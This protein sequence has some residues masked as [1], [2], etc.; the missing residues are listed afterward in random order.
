MKSTKT[1]LSAKSAILLLLVTVCSVAVVA[2]PRL[3][4]YVKEGLQNNIVAQQ[5]AIAYEQAQRSLQIATGFFLP[6]VSLLADYT[7][8]EG[9]RSIAIPVGDMLNPVYA[10]LNQLTQS[11]AFRQIDN[12]QQNFFP[13]NFYDGRIRTSMPLINTD[14]YANRAIQREQVAIRN[15]ELMAYKRQLVM[16]IKTAYYQYL[17]ATAAVKILESGLG[18]VERNVEVNA[19]LLRNGKALPANYQRSKSELERVRAELNS[20]QNRSANAKKYFNF[21][22]NRDLDTD[23]EIESADSEVTGELP[24][25][26][27]REELQALRSLQTVNEASLRM[28]KQVF[29]PKVNGFIDLGSQAAD[30]QWNTK[31][32]YYLVGV[33]LSMPIFQG[34]RNVMT[35]RNNASELKRTELELANTSNRLELSAQ[36]AEGD[37]LTARANHAAALEQ[38]KSAQSYFNLIEKGYVQGVNTLIEFLDARNQLTASALQQNLKRYEVLAAVARVERETAT[39]PLAP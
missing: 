6:S 29:I 27:V 36:V 23:V 16:E 20:A 25:A 33:Q 1:P 37:L 19:S 22:L 13:K 21:L 14:L 2:Q 3:E 39:Y 32:M 24:T 34:N 4:A 7:S 15:N 9:G 30:W 5:K 28:S 17:G 12:V 31:S 38:S 26:G 35:I 18:L 8:G 10:S 11:D